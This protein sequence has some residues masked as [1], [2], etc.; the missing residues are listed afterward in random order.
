MRLLEQAG[1]GGSHIPTLDVDLDAARELMDVNFIGTLGA[2]QTFAP[3]LVHT[4]KSGTG[5]CR[6]TI[7][8]AGSLVGTRGEEATITFLKTKALMLKVLHGYQD[9]R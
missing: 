9:S 5:D 2:C 3:M 6:A 1:Q 7:L 4:A 8:N